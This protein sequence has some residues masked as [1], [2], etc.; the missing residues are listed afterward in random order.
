V[1][2]QLKRLAFVQFVKPPLSMYYIVVVEQTFREI[3]MKIKNNN[4]KK[5]GE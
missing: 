1:A 5:V 2:P 3:H 4:F